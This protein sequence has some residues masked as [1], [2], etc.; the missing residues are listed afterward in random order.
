MASVAQRKTVKIPSI[1]EGVNLDVWYFKTE[2][3]GPHPVVIAGHG[4]V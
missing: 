4:W 1:E 2:G 3:P